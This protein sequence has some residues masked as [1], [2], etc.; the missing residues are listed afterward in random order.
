MNMLVVPMG[1]RSPFNGAS[2]DQ[3]WFRAAAPDGLAQAC[4]DV[5]ETDTAYTLSLDVPGFDKADIK[6]AIDTKRV[7]VQAKTP[8]PVEGRADM[9]RTRHL[10]K[11]YTLPQAVDAAASTAKLE[12]GVLTLTLVKKQPPQAAELTIN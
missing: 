2:F 8:E 6:V 1:L 4:V 7:T 9:R 3:A 10:S 11:A 5:V 12:H